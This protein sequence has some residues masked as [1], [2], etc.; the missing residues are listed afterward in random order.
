MPGAVTHHQR[1]RSRYG[2]GEIPCS[3]Q[4]HD[5]WIEK[6]RAQMADLPK[7]QSDVILDELRQMHPY[8]WTEAIESVDRHSDPLD[9]I[10]A[11]LAGC[12]L[13]GDECNHRRAGRPGQAPRLRTSTASHNVGGSQKERE[14]TTDYRNARR[15]L[16]EAR[17]VARENAETIV[18]EA[19]KA[20][21]DLE[22]IEAAAF[23]SQ[24]RAAIEADQALRALG[25]PEEARP[26]RSVYTEDG[27]DSYFIDLIAASSPRP[28]PGHPPHQAQARPRRIDPSARSTSTS[29]T[30]SLRGV[31]TSTERSSVASS[32]SPC[33]TATY[34]KPP[35]SVSSSTRRRG[36]FR[37]S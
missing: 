12:L 7:L 4:R 28:M 18:K 24:T 19:R 10:K 31:S 29:T 26:K 1:F 25:E 17:D 32:A 5:E 27:R 8:Q 6:A 21:R 2:F 30:R 13:A 11:V 20:H 35:A 16:R 37:S 3:R 36:C 15:E 14:M 9:V 22:P 23:K 34:R 33:S